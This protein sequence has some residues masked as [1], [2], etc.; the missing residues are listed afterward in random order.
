M[1]IVGKRVYSLGVIGLGA[2]Q[3][4]YGAFDPDWLPVPA[5]TPG[6][7]ILV[8][9][10]AGLLV[11]AGLGVNAPRTT[12]VAALALAVLFALLMLVFEAPHSVAKPADWG[13][14]QA[15]AESTAMAMGGL[16]AYAQSPGVGEAGATAVAR[17]ARLVFGLCLLVFGGSHF[18]YARF[19]ASLVPT[20]LPPSQLAWA[21]ATG[22]AQIAAGL[23]VLSG[24]QARLAAILLTVMYVGFGLLVHLPSVIAAPSSQANWTENAINLI[25]VGVAWSLADELSVRV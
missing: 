18:V 15:I 1:I 10:S 12:Q 6:Y 16:L 4:A 2:V 8:Y 19:T 20:W 3:L 13:G 17:I 7:A 23:A 22:A 21:Y 5:H 25:L 14:W 9:A 11:L 24:V